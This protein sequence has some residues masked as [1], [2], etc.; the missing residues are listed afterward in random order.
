MLI[1]RYATEFF[2]ETTWALL[3]HFPAQVLA[4]AHLLDLEV[5]T[6]VSPG[7]YCVSV[8]DLHARAMR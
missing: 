8:L 7:V 3:K 4:L 5:R 2:F 1:G 6:C